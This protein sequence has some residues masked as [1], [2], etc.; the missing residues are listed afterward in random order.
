MSSRSIAGT[1]KLIRIDKFSK[2]HIENV[3]IGLNDSAIFDIRDV[4]K[5][6]RR[7]RSIERGGFTLGISVIL[8]FFH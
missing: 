2:M 8:A 4:T 5:I 6:G 7:S 1:S 3:E